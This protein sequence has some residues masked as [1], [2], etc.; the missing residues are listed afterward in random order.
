MCKILVENC[1]KV[2]ENKFELVLVAVKNAKK[3]SSG[4]IKLSEDELKNKVTYLAL[5]NIENKFKNNDY[6]NNLP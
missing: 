4:K 2:V 3:I 1:L 5:K 6:N